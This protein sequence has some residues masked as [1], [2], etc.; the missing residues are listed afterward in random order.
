LL[1]HLSVRNEEILHQTRRTKWINLHYVLAQSDMKNRISLILLLFIGHCSFAQELK[2]FGIGSG[3]NQG[4]VTLNDGTKH[5]G[6]IRYNDVEGYISFR[7]SQAA[8]DQHV[9]KNTDILS[10]EYIKEGS[11]QRYYSLAFKNQETGQ[12]EINFYE[13]VREFKDFAVLS[14]K[15][16]MQ[17]QRADKNYSVPLAAG[18]IPAKASSLTLTQYEQ[19]FFLARDSNPELY[20]TM[21]YS[22]VDA[23]LYKYSKNVGYISNNNIASKYFGDYWPKV[24]QHLKER[25]ITLDTRDA[26]VTALNFYVALLEHRY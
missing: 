10:L 9:F 8:D 20:L 4:R 6:E 18:F 12:E 16:I 23:T 21:E 13:V 14:K 2:N 17:A 3:W 15:D 11:L 25:K 22:Y 19:F 26:L 5:F 1:K 7:T 24:K